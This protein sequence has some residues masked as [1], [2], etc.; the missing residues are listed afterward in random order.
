MFH[1][2][3]KVK[4]V[5]ISETTAPT[6]LKLYFPVSLHTIRE[7]CILGLSLYGLVWL[8][9]TIFVPQYNKSKK[10]LYFRNYCTYGIE[11]IF[12]CIPTSHRQSRSLLEQRLRARNS[13]RSK[14]S[15]WVQVGRN[16]GASGS[17]TGSGTC[18][19]APEHHAPE[20]RTE[21]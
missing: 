2:T 13:T 17:G 1:S 19:G 10:R 7:Y 6:G 20:R 16:F 14:C 3:T 18:S 11:A 4:N 9:S 15:I 5:Y 12:S 21:C 8:K